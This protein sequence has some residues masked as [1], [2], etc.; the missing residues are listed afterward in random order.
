MSLKARLRDAIGR[1][2]LTHGWF[3]ALCARFTMRLYNLQ[4]YLSTKD[5][6]AKYKAAL[7]R[8][9]MDV[10]GELATERI[11]VSGRRAIFHYP[12]GCAFHVS[13]SKES[14][15]GALFSHGGYEAHETRLMAAS[16]RPGASVVD[17]GANF[18]W[19]A[20]HLA[21]R[22]GESGKVLAF[23]PIPATY[24]ELEENVAINSCGN[25]TLFRVALGSENR[26]VTLRLP[27]T[28]G[29]AGAASQ[30]L[31]MGEKV[32]VSMV[33]L[34]DFLDR[35]GVPTVDF[36]K[37]DIEGGELALLRGAERLLARCHPVIFIEI[38]DIHCRRFGH[39]P[40]DVIDHLVG[41]GYRG[42][43]IDEN[44]ALIGIDF[45][46]PRNGNYLFEAA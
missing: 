13:A 9:F 41:H 43:Y 21:R 33:R 18:G 24:A 29:G 3:V 30:F 38:V 16:V 2:Q 45:R 5:L 1:N 15:S 34:D 27:T 39:T 23:E 11:V 44:G 35:E 25:I 42:S 6:R 12:D 36:I 32:D 37:A 4:T 31:D 40:L 46:R 28:E 22:A 17:A 26:Q 14:I 7:W 20:V 19:H 8:R 10:A